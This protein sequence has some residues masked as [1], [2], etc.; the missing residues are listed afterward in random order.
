VVSEAMKSTSSHDSSGG[1]GGSIVNIS[2]CFYF[3]YVLLIDLI[4]VSDIL[5]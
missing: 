1:G 2:S 5:G 3:C 4:N